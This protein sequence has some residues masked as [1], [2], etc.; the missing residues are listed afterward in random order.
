MRNRLDLDADK[1]LQLLLDNSGLSWSELCS[2]CGFQPDA[3]H[4]G[5]M[6]LYNCLWALADAGLV[7]FDGSPKEDLMESLR[8]VLRGDDNPSKFRA[9]ESWIKIQ[10]VLNER[11]MGA[12]RSRN[13][14]SILVHPVFGKPSELPKQTD[15][16]VLMPFAESIKAVY[17]DH[18]R[19]VAD[20]LGLSISRADD[21]FSNNS[22]VD[23]IWN[24]ICGAGTIIADCTGR[25]PNVFY[26]IGIAHTVGKPVI[27]VTQETSDVPA[28]VRHIK[29][30]HYDYTPRGMT[31]LEKS[32]EET[33][34]STMGIYQGMW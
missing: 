30:L 29:C 10:M 16:F 6:Q 9:S 4:P 32:L 21:I 31:Q 26:E 1:V 23:D 18:I 14:D 19:S 17:D 11:F 22:I 3:R 34:H 27:L 2:E 15:I 7:D 24:S 28:D 33:I 13:A 8:N 25:N 5:P 20:R 12:N